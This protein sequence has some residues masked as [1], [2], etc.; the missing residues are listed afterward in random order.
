MSEG[1]KSPLSLE[2]ESLLKEIWGDSLYRKIQSKMTDL[3]S[4]EGT[5]AE[6]KTNQTIAQTAQSFPKKEQTLPPLPVKLIQRSDLI[7]QARAK[8]L[9]D[10]SLAIAKLNS[11]RRSRS[12]KELDLTLH[13]VFAGSPGTGKTSF[14]RFYAQEIKSAGLLSKGHLIE[15]SRKDLVAEFAGQTAGKV[16]GIVEKSLGG[17]LFIDEA[18]SLKTNADDAFGQECI[19][20][21]VKLIE[22]HRGDF[23]LILAGYTEEMRNFLHLNSGLKSRIPHFVEFEDYSDTELSQIFD[24]MIQK[25]G[26]KVSPQNKAHLLK[27]LGLKRKSR[28]FGNAREVRNLIER[29]LIQHAV[30]LTKGDLKSLS[31]DDFEQLIYSDFTENPDDLSHSAPVTQAGRALKE[32][33]KLVGL[34]NIKTEI[35][36]M[37]SFLQVAQMRASPTL[38]NF[39][40]HMIFSGNPGTGKTHVARL[41]GE[42]YKELGLLSDGHV[43]EVDRAALVASY[44]GQTAEKT[45]AKIKEALGG[46]LFIDEAYTLTQNAGQNDS[47]GREAVETLLKALEDFRGKFAVVLAGYPEEMGRFLSANPGLSSRM[48]TVLEFEDYS[49]AELHEMGKRLIE[50]IGFNIEEKAIFMLTQILEQRRSKGRHFGNARELRNVIEAAIK[51]QAERHTTGSTLK[52]IS[53]TELNLLKVEDFRGLLARKT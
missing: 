24:S 18:Y 47:Y 22:D 8:T 28:S 50:E 37:L 16:A 34:K 29:A 49:S 21:L 9:I 48:P 35:Q 12:L 11:E 38:N 27:E 2:Q 31:N 4:S 20:T 19:D 41:L 53:Q 25:Y 23:V 13:A 10:Q 46:I 42:I 45:Q 14:A 17:V 1:K 5:K 15:V 32:L 26:M 36:K 40:L 7:G 43:V 51:N 33:Q 3:K 52:N 44:M 6:G 39:N 30:R